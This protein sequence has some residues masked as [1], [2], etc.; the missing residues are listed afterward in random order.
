MTSKKVFVSFDWDND[1]HYK[2]LL[3]AWHA[4][5][6]FD[7]IFSDTTPREIDSF[8]VGRIKAGLTSKIKLATHT[9][10]IV[11]QYANARHVKSAFIG[12]TNWINFEAYQSRQEG[13]KLAVVKLDTSYSVPEELV[14]SNYSWI[15]NF[16]EK[17][18]IAVLNH[19]SKNSYA[20]F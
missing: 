8:D 6:E 19:S 18:V 11:G 14:G 16:T 1:R 4:N 15:A 12:F 13:N 9:L 2:Y 10:F 20:S 3:E 7:F 5:P 17:N